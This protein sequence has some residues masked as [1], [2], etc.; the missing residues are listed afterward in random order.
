MRNGSVTQL[1]HG[2]FTRQHPLLTVALLPAPPQSQVHPVAW[3]AGMT[4]MNGAEE[5][6]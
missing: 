6:H 1:F 3:Q 2:Y 5:L 4:W